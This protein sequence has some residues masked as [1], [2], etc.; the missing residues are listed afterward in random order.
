MR[1]KRRKFWGWRG[2]GPHG[3]DNPW[4]G[5][6]PPHT[7]QPCGRGE[8]K[9]TAALWIRVEKDDLKKLKRKNEENGWELMVV[10][11]TVSDQS[12]LKVNVKFSKRSDDQEFDIV[13][14][15]GTAW[16]NYS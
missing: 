15:P 10:T 2:T 13:L 8:V 4:M 9:P 14:S 12:E 7:G 11:G 3:G 1:A 16:E 6:G 5:W